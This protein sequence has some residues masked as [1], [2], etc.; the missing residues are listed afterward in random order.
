LEENNDFVL[1]S[2]HST[3]RTST[4]KTFK[5]PAV[6]GT[7]A[8]CFAKFKVRGAKYSN[9]RAGTGTGTSSAADLLVKGNSSNLLGRHLRREE[10]GERTARQMA[11]SGA[12]SST[13]SSSSWSVPAGD[14]DPVVAVGEQEVAIIGRE[15]K[16]VEADVGTAENAGA[17]ASGD[18]TV[19]AEADYTCGDESCTVDTAT[20]ED[21]IIPP[22]LERPASSE[23]T[24]DNDQHLDNNG[25]E[26]RP[27]AT[28][29]DKHLR[30]RTTRPATETG[31]GAPS[32]VVDDE[33]C[34]PA[35]SSSVDRQDTSEVFPPTG[36]HTEPPP[37]PEKDSDGGPPA[38]DDH[39]HSDPSCGDEDCST[40][41]STGAAFFQV[42]RFLELMRAPTGVVRD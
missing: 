4:S 22:D 10:K 23:E 35:T 16:E 20:A 6:R 39:G 1:G 41:T 26:H 28:S 13:F 42:D 27:E 7:G 18:T 37:A 2:L 17:P 14:V 5:A 30:P 29:D 9:S 40:T 11:A 32:K 33:G 24:V 38:D 8:S 25:E 36:Q 12:A 19:A 15:P 34:S 21:A 3:S 31:D